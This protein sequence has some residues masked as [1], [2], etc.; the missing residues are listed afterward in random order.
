M[1][2]KLMKGRRL[3]AIVLRHR[4]SGYTISI[5]PYKEDSE[6]WYVIKHKGGDILNTNRYSKVD[7]DSMGEK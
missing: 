1:D 5:T 3:K 7:Y 4:N 2:P 6:Y